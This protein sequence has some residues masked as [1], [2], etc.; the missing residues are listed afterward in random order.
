[1]NQSIISGRLTRDPE[2]RYVSGSGTAVCKI[3]LAV[4]RGFGREK[5]E[6]AKAAG[7]QTANFIPVVIWGNQGEYAAQNLSKGSK[8]TILGEISTGSYKTESGEMRY[9]FNVTA[10]QVEYQDR[11]DKAVDQADDFVETSLG[12]E[13]IP[14]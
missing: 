10:R 4:D 12:D 5:R 9:T 7:K 2:L 11:R 14:F 1:L 3:S 8:V 13:E 6:E